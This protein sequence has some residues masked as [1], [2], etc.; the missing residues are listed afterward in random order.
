MAGWKA[1]FTVVKSF[2][3][4]VAA[5][6]AVVIVFWLISVVTGFVLFL[7]KL[8]IAVAIVFFAVAYFVKK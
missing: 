2:L 3:L 6:I 5:I 1:K 8:I 7:A 4:A